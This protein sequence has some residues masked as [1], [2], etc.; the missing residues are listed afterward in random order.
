MRAA[1]ATTVMAIV[2]IVPFSAPALAAGGPSPAQVRAAVHRA[3]AST[4]LWATINICNSRRDRDDL[5]VRGQMPTLGF[6]AGLSMRIQVEYYST[7]KKRFMPIQS[8]TAIRV[9]SLGRWSKNLQQAGAEFPF[10][11]HAGL[12]SATIQFTWRRG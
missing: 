9:I 10:K 12:L 1:L 2:M 7:A 11:A 6:S 8:S 5:G 3:E 4:A